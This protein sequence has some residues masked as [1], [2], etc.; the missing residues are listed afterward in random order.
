[1]YIFLFWVKKVKITKIKGVRRVEGIKRDRGIKKGVFYGKRHIF[2]VF[3][4]FTL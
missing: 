2:S 3:S 4:T 1:M